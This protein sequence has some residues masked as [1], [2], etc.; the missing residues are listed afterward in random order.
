MAARLARGGIAHAA[1]FPWEATVD[2]LLGV[3]A[4]VLSVLEPAAAS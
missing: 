4:E 1:R 3:Y 2:R